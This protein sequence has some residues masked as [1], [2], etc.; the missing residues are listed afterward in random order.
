MKDDCPC[1]SGGPV[2]GRRGVLGLG[3][4]AAS[5]ATTATA[6]RA[7]ED[8]PPIETPPG[9]PLGFTPL[10]PT[11]AT[12]PPPGPRHL[13]FRHL[14]TE[15]NLE[16]VY[17][18]EGRYVWDALQAV[19]EHL[20]DFRSLEV[21][22]IDVRVLD[23]LFTLQALTGSK[24]PFRIISAFRS[25]A[26]NEMLQ[27]QSAAV[28]GSSQVAR[29]SLHMEGKAIDMRLNDVSLTG[30]RDAALALQGGGVGYYPDSGFVHVDIGPVRT[31]Q[32]T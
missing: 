1:C 30:L 27:D 16:V 9:S 28:N 32:G 25:P 26:T 7:R 8:E 19:N 10:S 24:E 21:H 4:I 2:L 14:H 5:L 6:A 18:D 20:S 13:K 22:P 15:K 11:P 31:W 29:K 23:I 17:W 12:P 3:L